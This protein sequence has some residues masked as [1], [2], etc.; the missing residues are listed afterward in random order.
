M[1]IDCWGFACHAY[2][3]LGLRLSCILIVGASP[4]FLFNV[5]Y[6]TPFWLLRLRL[7]SCLS[8]LITLCVS[9]WGFACYAYWLL[10]LRL[11]YCLMFYI[12]PRFGSWG[13]ACFIVWCFIL[14]PVLVL[15]AS[16][17]FLIGNLIFILCLLAIHYLYCP[18]LYLILFNVL[19]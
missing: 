4:A 11:L 12:T 8:Y 19:T 1:H 10:G 6:Y 9:Y 3:L 14:H 7:L 15:E 13:F 16:P 18:P 5:L 2:W 17:A